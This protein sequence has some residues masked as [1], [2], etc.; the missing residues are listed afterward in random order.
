M[1]TFVEHL[2]NEVRNSYQRLNVEKLHELLGLCAELQNIPSV[3]QVLYTILIAIVDNKQNKYQFSFFPFLSFPENHA[4]FLKLM[5]LKIFQDLEDDSLMPLIPLV[6]QWEIKEGRE[7]ESG[8]WQLCQTKE[9]LSVLHEIIRHDEQLFG[10]IV[11]QKLNPFLIRKLNDIASFIFK[12]YSVEHY[13][14]FI[15]LIKCADLKDEAQA[16]F[17]K[18]LLTHFADI[19]QDSSLFDLAEARDFEKVI[20]M[21]MDV[22]YCFFNRQFDVNDILKS[23]FQGKP[24]EDIQEINEIIYSISWMIFNKILNCAG[25]NDVNKLADFVGLF[26]DIS[27][28][29]RINL[30]YVSEYSLVS[31][32]LLETFGSYVGFMRLCFEYSKVLEAK[33]VAIT[34]RKLCKEFFVSIRG[35]FKSDIADSSF[36]KEVVDI[37]FAAGNNF[38]RRNRK[39]FVFRSSSQFFPLVGNEISSKTSSMMEVG[40][41]QQSEGRP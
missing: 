9:G 14:I 16:S 30:T 33:V 19:V 39:E 6:R 21:F 23:N 10:K 24:R 36:K 2:L 28:N 41:C 31:D 15:V 1:P 5:R 25:I 17:V 13:F 4:L 34:M 18:L 8:L 35:F 27:N 38:I 29:Y 32:V 40:V 20:I 37:V 26:L 12:I 3:R 22:I 11:F 7:R